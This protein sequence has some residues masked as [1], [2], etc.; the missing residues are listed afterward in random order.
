MIYGL[1]PISSIILQ[2]AVAFLRKI[3]ELKFRVDY[4]NRKV[5]I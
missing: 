4:F 1:A 5:Y 2:T 3:C